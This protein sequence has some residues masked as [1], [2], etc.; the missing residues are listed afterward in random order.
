[1]SPGLSPDKISLDLMLAV[2]AEIVLETTVPETTSVIDQTPADPAM[3]VDRTSA[4]APGI[5]PGT[6][7]TSDPTIAPVEIVPETIA[8]ETIAPVETVLETTVPETTSAIVQTQA[9][10]ATS[11]DR[12]SA[13]VP[14]IVPET[15]LAIVP[16]IALATGLEI[17]I[18]ARMDVP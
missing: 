3:S 17:V 5:F 13:I 6:A 8:P 9:D 11:D 16:E 12:T 18:I 15:S 1:M 7:Q 4:I 2:P 14:E 10:P